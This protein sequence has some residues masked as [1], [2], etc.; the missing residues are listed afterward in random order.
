M[1]AGPLAAI[2]VT[3]ALAS[4]SPTPSRFARAIVPPTT[5]R[6]AVVL[7]TEVYE[8]ARPDLGDLRVVDASGTA[9][10]YLLEKGEVAAGEPLHPAVLNRS[11]V[12]RKTAFVT[13]DFGSRVRK[14]ELTLSLTGDSFR[15]RVSVEGSDDGQ[16]W[17]VLTDTAYVF[18]V[19]GPNPAR[20]ETVSFPEND[21]P[22]LRVGVFAEPDDSAKVEILEVTVRRAGRAPRETSRRI[23]PALATDERARET[24]LTVDLGAR[25]QPF[26]ALELDVEEARF[27]RG[28]VVEARREPSARDRG[29]HPLDWRLLGEGA[30]YRYGAEDGRGENLRIEVTGRERVLRVRV[31]NRDDQPLHVRAVT[32]RSPVERLLFEGQADR[33]Y[34]L[35]YGSPDLPAPDYDLGRTADPAAWATAPEATLT[36]GIRQPATE[37]P[38]PWTERHRTP[39]LLGLVVIV[40]LLGLVTWRALRAAG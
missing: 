7:D 34:L 11:F 38:A 26:R 17:V 37:A 2:A 25:H 13:L 8:G 14:R 31:R 9:V 36:P 23:V 29:S 16:R 12:G 33:R 18:A 27:F 39:L 19:P 20:Y 22:R 4:G 28:V 35:T 32:V 6:T 21:L 1:S 40:S 24:L 10:P 30:L 3:L 5:G 15:R